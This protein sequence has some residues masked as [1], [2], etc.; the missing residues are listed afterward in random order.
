[1]STLEKRWKTFVEWTQVHILVVACRK[2]GSS[3]LDAG[4][5]STQLHCCLCRATTHF[6]D[7]RFVGLR[8]SQ[9][10]EGMTQEQKAS[11]L[12]KLGQDFGYPSESDETLKSKDA[13]EGD[14][15]HDLLQAMNSFL[16]EF[17]EISSKLNVDAEARSR[18]RHEW[19]ATKARLDI[20]IGAIHE[21]G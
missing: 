19:E 8:V 13:Q 15:H 5:P 20:I 11:F 21:N 12:R 3:Y 1:M 4:L 10:F 7:E 14:L 6:D 9:P 18:L 2:C 16:S 17:S